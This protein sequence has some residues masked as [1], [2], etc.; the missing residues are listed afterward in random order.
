MT[1]SRR[2]SGARA[3]RVQAS[4]VLAGR[5]AVLIRGASGSGKSS[6]ALA[7]LSRDGPR[8]PVRLVADDAVDLVATSGRPVAIAPEPITGLLE[9]RGVGVISVSAERRAVVGLVVDLQPTSPPERLPETA[10][11]RTKLAGTMVPRLA[12]MAH[13]WDNAERVLAALAA[14]AADATFPVLPEDHPA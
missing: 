8:R 9:V 11:A 12:L 6:L 1:A 10:D 4:C 13:A 7:L 3:E 5:H 14:L 2:E